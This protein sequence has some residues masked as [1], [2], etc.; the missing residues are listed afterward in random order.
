MCILEAWLGTLQIDFFF[1]PIA[2]YPGKYQWSGKPN[3]GDCSLEVLE[4]NITFDDGLWQCQVTSSDFA[5]QDALASEEARLVVREPPKTIGIVQNKN[6]IAQGEQIT[7]VDGQVRGH[8]AWT[9]HYCSY[10]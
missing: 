10:V 4:A 2:T 9:G 8:P 1:Q 3:L 5:A 7:V 6:K